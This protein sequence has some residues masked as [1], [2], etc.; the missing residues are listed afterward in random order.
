MPPGIGFSFQ[1][2]HDAQQSMQDAPFGPSPSAST[3]Q[4]AVQIRSLRVPKTLPSNA[5]VSRSLLTAPGSAAP[6]GNDLTSFVQALRQLFQPQPSQPDAPMRPT[7]PQQGP[8]PSQGPA[9][10]GNY[11]TDPL[12]AAPPFD[13]TQAP[14]QEFATQADQRPDNIPEEIWNLGPSYGASYAQLSGATGQPYLNRA[15]KPHFDVGNDPSAAPRG[16]NT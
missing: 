7:F 6:G 14:A 4:Q 3:P 9:F 1:P 12:Q 2:G 15:P 11:D 13:F 5:P 10:E 16:F 8:M